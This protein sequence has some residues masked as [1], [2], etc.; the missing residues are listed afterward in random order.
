MPG[1]PMV[2]APMGRTV[3][4]IPEPP[5][6]QPPVQG[7]EYE[8][9]QTSDGQIEASGRIAATYAMHFLPGSST[10]YAEYMKEL[11]GKLHTFRNQLSR[12]AA[13]ERALAKQNF[14]LDD[15]RLSRD[16][17]RLRQLGSLNELIREHHH[18][19][20]K[21]GMNAERIRQWLGDDPD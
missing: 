7:T 13:E 10:K 1:T 4:C 6:P 9:P 8:L 11:T 20:Q 5:K 17:N 19:Q 18:R 14:E 12:T 15:E 3:L 16:I 21:S 2:A